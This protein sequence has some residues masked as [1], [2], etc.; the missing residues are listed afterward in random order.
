MGGEWGVVVVTCNDVGWKWPES[1]VSRCLKALYSKM[2]CHY[3][4]LEL[5]FILQLL[6]Y[7]LYTQ[8][9]QYGV[10]GGVE[11]GGSQRQQNH[12]CSVSTTAAAV[13]ARARVKRYC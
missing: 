1:N 10:P 6:M 4:L 9:R 7:C 12:G 8:Y 2:A 3:L 13:A 11:L 5:L